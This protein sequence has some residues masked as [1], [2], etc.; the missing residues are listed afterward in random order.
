MAGPWGRLLLCL[1]AFCLA[2][3]S[4]TRG[5]KVS[6][7][8]VQGDTGFRGGSRKG[9]Y[10][11]WAQVWGHTGQRDQRAV[12]VCPRPQAAVWVQLPGLAECRLALLRPCS[13]CQPPCSV[14]SRPAAPQAE[15]EGDR[16]R[17]LLLPSLPRLRLGLSVNPAWGL[18]LGSPP[19]HG[20]ASKRT[21]VEHTC[22]CPRP[23]LGR[24]EVCSPLVL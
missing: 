20:E 23:A 9:A 14:G 4:F 11:G 8:Q 17:L 1:L 2:G 5:Q 24:K 21:H 16:A 19:N 6:V 7:S 12:L 18:K 15:A 22:V 10:T 13:A 3:S